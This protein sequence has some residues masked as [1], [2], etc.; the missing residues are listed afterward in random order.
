MSRVRSALMNEV[1]TP[2]GLLRRNTD[3]AASRKVACS[4]SRLIEI[5]R[6]RSCSPPLQSGASDTEIWMRDER[7]TPLPFHSHH[8]CPVARNNPC[9]FS[10][11]IHSPRSLGRERT[12]TNLPLPGRWPDRRHKQ[13]PVDATRCN[14]R[15]IIGPLSTIVFN[16]DLLQFAS[17]HF[18]R[19]L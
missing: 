17:V 4:W 16:A 18:H 6:H 14:T 7:E 19:T 5:C 2:L 9:F 15:C 8:L 1:A 12:T 10:L 3:A 13:T 11:V